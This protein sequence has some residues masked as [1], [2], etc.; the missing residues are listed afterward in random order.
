MAKLGAEINKDIMQL[1]EAVSGEAVSQ[2]RDLRA[3]AKFIPQN[4]SNMCAALSGSFS[5]MP[6]QVCDQPMMLNLPVPQSLWN[7]QHAAS[8][9]C[10]SFYNRLISDTR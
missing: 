3:R 8:A 10:L 5:I 6:S 2:L 9:A 1:L 7:S 4:L